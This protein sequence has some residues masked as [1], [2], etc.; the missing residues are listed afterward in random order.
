MKFYDCNFLYIS[1]KIFL[2]YNIHLSARQYLL[3]CYHKQT[4]WHTHESAWLL[5]VSH[6]YMCECTSIHIVTIIVARITLDSY[7]SNFDCFNNIYY[8]WLLVWNFAIPF[9]V[10]FA[11][12]IAHAYVKA[13]F[14][15]FSGHFIH[16]FNIFVRLNF[17][18]P[19]F[20][21][22]VTLPFFLLLW[23]GQFSW[24]MRDSNISK[25]SVFYIIWIQTVHG[26]Q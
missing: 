13:K 3:F 11:F 12:S 22:N 4:H 9:A 8:L 10:F 1:V 14:I 6:V 18:S 7:V 23:S 5:S 17:D 26:L 20:A 2:F 21:M 19:D 15:Y 16:P 24:R 25:P